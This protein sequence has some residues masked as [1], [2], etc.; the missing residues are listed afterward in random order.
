MNAVHSQADGNSSNSLQDHEARSENNLTGEILPSCFLMGIISGFSVFV[1][2][3]QAIFPGLVAAV[4]GA[5]F[6]V[7]F[8]CDENHN[9]STSG[10]KQIGK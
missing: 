3:G 1:A 5:L 7:F 2:F 10:R 8:A 4:I 9:R 6:G